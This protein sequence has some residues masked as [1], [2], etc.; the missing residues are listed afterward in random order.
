[1]GRKQNLYELLGLGE[2]AST[3]QVREAFLRRSDEVRANAA[4]LPTQ[5][6]TDRLQLLKLALSTL[7]D[8]VTRDAY[9]RKLRVQSRMPLVVGG[10]P[11]DGPA[12]VSSTR[13][14]A[15]S[16]RADA[17]SL[18]AD[19]MLLR[20]SAGL[21]E[22]AGA[23]FLQTAAGGFLQRLA[24]AIGLLVIVG[25]LAALA[26]RFFFSSPLRQQAEMETRQSK[27]A[28]QAALQE[29]Y[30]AHGVRPANMAELQLL[31]AQRRGQEVEQRQVRQDEEKKA[32]E[33][34][35]F[36]D[37]ARRRAE[38]VSRDLQQSEALARREAQ[39]EADRA[40]REA[41]RKEQLEAYKQAEERRRQQEN[42]RQWRE[43]LRR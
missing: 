23:G 30:Q 34:Q 15:L 8:P 27:A 2:H 17:L 29:Y 5:Q 24:N 39:A 35:R 6:V 43:I 18:R 36:E 31:E 32:R 38:Q 1:M 12:G 40:A 37:D 10:V 26:G 14:D 13:A 9:D 33:A 20:S 7:I 11:T 25:I 19:A 28:E 3:E 21:G 16:M 41:A 42:E 22:R 4:G